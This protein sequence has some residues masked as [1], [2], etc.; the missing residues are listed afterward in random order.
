MNANVY[1]GK[2][3]IGECPQESV[4]F[5]PT[6]HV[7]LSE[8]MTVPTSFEITVPITGSVLQQPHVVKQMYRGKFSRKVKKQIAAYWKEHEE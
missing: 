4:Q 2:T 3:Y 7:L 1:F 6:E 8:A 5:K